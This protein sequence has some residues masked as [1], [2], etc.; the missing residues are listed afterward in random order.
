[1][2]KERKN[3]S[4]KATSKEKGRTKKVVEKV[5]KVVRRAYIPGQKR[6]T[7]VGGGGEEERYH[8]KTSHKRAHIK[9][10]YIQTFMFT[11]ACINKYMT[12]TH[13]LY[14]QIMRA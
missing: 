10:A 9:H 8:R 11:D 13:N 2:G 5:E 12:N 4:N 3:I 7:R 1:M 14:L 6:E